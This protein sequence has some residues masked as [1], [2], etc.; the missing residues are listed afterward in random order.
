MHSGRTYGPTDLRGPTD[1]RGHGRTDPRASWSH[2]KCSQNPKEEKMLGMNSRENWGGRRFPVDVYSVSSTVHEALK[3]EA[4]QGA[5][6]GAARA[7]V[8]TI[9]VLFNMPHLEN[10]IWPHP[11]I[12]WC[13]KREH[14][15]NGYWPSLLN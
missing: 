12:F 15:T 6:Q 5:E 1:P 11:S 13:W 9:L 10:A 7:C 2:L 3:C 4:E 8:S 14:A